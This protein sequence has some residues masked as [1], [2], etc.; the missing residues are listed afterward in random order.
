MCEIQDS[1]AEKKDQSEKCD[2]YDAHLG[3][4]FST[5]VWPVPKKIRLHNKFDDFYIT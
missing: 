5:S 4:T 2:I 1:L 3:G